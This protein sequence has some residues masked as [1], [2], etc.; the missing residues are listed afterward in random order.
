MSFNWETI[1]VS[2]IYKF[3]K[4]YKTSLNIMN[5]I[6]TFEYFLRYN[7]YNLD[8]NSNKKSFSQIRDYINIEYMNDI[9]FI[10]N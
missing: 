8:K 7:S 4:K 9:S 1:L 6:D 3:Y 5:S 10:I 2:P